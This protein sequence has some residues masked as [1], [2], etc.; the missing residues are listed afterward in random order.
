VGAHGSKPVS[1]D[2]PDGIVERL[3]HGAIRRGLQFRRVALHGQADVGRHRDGVTPG[4]T[5]RQALDG[6]G[7]TELVEDRRTQLADQA[8]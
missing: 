6:R 2:V 5:R 4:R 1:A 8:A 3:L 7:R